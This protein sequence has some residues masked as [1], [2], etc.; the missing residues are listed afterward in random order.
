MTEE[1][2]ENETAISRLVY[3]FGGGLSPHRR[4]FPATDDLVETL[5]NIEHLH[6]DGLFDMNSWLKAFDVVAKMVLGPDWMTRGS[7]IEDRFGRNSRQW[8]IYKICETRIKLNVLI[9]RKVKLLKLEDIP[10]VDSGELFEVE[11]DKHRSMY[12][13]SLGFMLG[14]LIMEYNWKFTHED[15]AIEGLRWREGRKRAQPLGV[16]AL[17]KSG[18]ERREAIRDIARHLIAEDSTL[19]GNL[20]A[21]ARA[22]LATGDDRLSRGRG[23]LVSEDAVRKHLTALRQQGDL[24]E[25]S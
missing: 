15:S 18:K 13:S 1:N 2:Q 17:Q 16:Q 24:W 9:V 20:S 3:E 21:L 6:Y 11:D 25:S 8:Y 12:A 5:A 19:F 7:E 14:M 22:I 10:K 4:E 23:L